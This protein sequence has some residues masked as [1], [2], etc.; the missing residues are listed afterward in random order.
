MCIRDR[1]I[2]S[3]PRI[4]P[5][6]LESG[7]SANDLAIKIADLTEPRS[8]SDALRVAREIELLSEEDAVNR[9][10]R[11][12]HTA[13]T[14]GELPTLVDRGGL[15]NGDAVITNAVRALL[16]A[17]AFIPEVSVA[18][19]SPRQPRS[20]ASERLPSVRLTELSEPDM[21]RLVALLL[22]LIHI[23]VKIRLQDP[24]P[25]V[26]AHVANERKAVCYSSVV[27]ENVNHPSDFEDVSDVAV[28]RNIG[29]YRGHICDAS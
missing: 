29:G 22:S 26:V 4:L 11:D 20:D 18:L 8:S 16:S 2:L 27:T 24:L 19:V 7:D 25:L 12:L 23:S 6:D 9:A 28:Q 15:L 5:I 1:D 17:A 21:R 13:I 14:L 3:L 10:V